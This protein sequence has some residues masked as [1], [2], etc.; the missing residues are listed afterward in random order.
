M[1]NYFLSNNSTN[2]IL[3]HSNR[4][5]LV[6]CHQ[7]NMQYNQPLLKYNNKPHIFQYAK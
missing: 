2:L 5:K 3:H 6:N 7:N 1:T 4:K